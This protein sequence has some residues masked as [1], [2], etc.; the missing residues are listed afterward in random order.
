M[1]TTTFRS[2]AWLFCVA[3]FVLAAAG[4]APAATSAVSTPLNPPMGEEP[5][6][7]GWRFQALQNVN[8]V[9][10]GA[11]DPIPAGGLPSSMD[12]GIWTD[13]GTLLGS[14]IVPAGT[15]GTLIDGYFYADLTTPISLTTGDFYRIADSPTSGTNDNDYMFSGVSITDSPAV[16]YDQGYLVENTNSLVF[17]TVAGSS[18]DF[19]GPNFQYVP[20]PTS[21]AL[22]A[23]GFAACAGYRSPKRK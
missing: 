21:F 6:C 11:L 2:F 7:V 8:V 18:D 13:S 4:A 5:W 12:V 3:L 17:P 23:L 1:N 9:S 10:L 15:A 19:F 22:L 20:E 16:D 14:L